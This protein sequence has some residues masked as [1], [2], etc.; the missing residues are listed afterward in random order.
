MNLE[1]NMVEQ[2]W[3]DS[4]REMMGVTE[5]AKE[6][7][8]NRCILHGL[9]KANVDFKKAREEAAVIRMRNEKGLE[10]S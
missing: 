4:Q 5:A 6:D 3:R 2:Q 10:E 8:L 1:F 7:C 9:E